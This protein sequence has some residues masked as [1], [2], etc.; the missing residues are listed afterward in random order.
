M[1]HTQTIRDTSVGTIEKIT[2]QCSSTSTQ[3]D[4]EEGAKH[5]EKELTRAISE[6]ER[7]N[8]EKSK[9]KIE[10]LRMK[11]KITQLE[12]QLEKSDKQIKTKDDQLESMKKTLVKSG[13]VAN[14]SNQAKNTTNDKVNDTVPKDIGYSLYNSTSLDSKLQQFSRD[15]FSTVTKIVNEKFSILQS[16]VNI[17]EKISENCKTFKSALTENLPLTSTT[18]D[19]KEIINQSRN[20]QLVQERERKLCSTNI[21]VH[22]VKEVV[23]EIKEE[24]D[25]EFVNAFLGRIGVSIKPI[26]IIRLGK[27]EPSK[28]RPLKIKLEIEKE[29]EVVMSRLS[30]LKNAEDR[31]KKISVTVEERQDIRNWVEKAKEKNQNESGNFIWKARGSPKNGMRLVKFAKQ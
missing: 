5:V 8:T 31:F 19:F 18:T 4:N 6:L 25:D 15:I 7:V 26:S 10:N 30:N 14:K 23:D 22:G 1:N 20:N 28:T 11:L 17:P 24:N 3:T 2:I 21:I 13:V 12:D 27:P 29:Q 9:H 16:L